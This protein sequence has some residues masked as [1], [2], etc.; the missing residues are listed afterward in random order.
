MCEGGR[1]GSNLHLLRAVVPEGVQRLERERSPVGN[2]IVEIQQIRFS[3]PLGMRG[4][5]VST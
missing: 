1:R 4:N 2:T 5:S 3:H